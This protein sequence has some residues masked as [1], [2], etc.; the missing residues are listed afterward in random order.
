MGDCQVF[1]LCKQT[2]HEASMAKLQPRYHIAILQ[3]TFCPPWTP[4]M[5]RAGQRDIPK[6]SELTVLIHKYPQH[7]RLPHLPSNSNVARKLHAHKIVEII[8]YIHAIPRLSKTEG[9]TGSRGT[10]YVLN[11][12]KMN[13]QALTAIERHPS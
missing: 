5:P 3:G 4:Q 9:N 10:N 11:S 1:P 2:L 6:C 13:A 7:T 12:Y 8:P